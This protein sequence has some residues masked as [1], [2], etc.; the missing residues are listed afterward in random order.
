MHNGTMPLPPAPT[1]PAD[2]LAAKSFEV[3]AR[4]A[5]RVRNTDA[6]DPVATPQSKPVATKKAPRGPKNAR[7]T[8][9]L[10]SHG[11]TPVPPSPRL[12]TPVS[13]R[14]RKSAHPG[15]AKL[16]VLDTN[17]LLQVPE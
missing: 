17:V 5:P 10:P 3:K 9:L 14:L 8:G 7:V 12:A 15:P 4:S 13:S 11:L 2:R 6:T 1:K 16:F